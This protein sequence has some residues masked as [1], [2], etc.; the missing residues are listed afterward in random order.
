MKVHLPLNCMLSAWLSVMFLCLVPFVLRAEKPERSESL[1]GIPA[2]YTE[3]FDGVSAPNLPAGWTYYAQHAYGNPWVQTINRI[4]APSQPN[5][6]E[7]SSLFAADEAA[8]LLFISPELENI[9]QSAIRFYAGTGS[10]SAPPDLVV[11]TMS[12]PTDPST[13]VPIKTIS[14]LGYVSMKQYLV[15]MTQASPEARYIA[16]RHG[17]IKEGNF[18]SILL[19]NFQYESNSGCIEPSFLQAEGRSTTTAYLQWTENGTAEKWEVKYGPSGFNPDQSGNKINFTGNLLAFTLSFLEPSTLYDFYVR[20]MCSPTNPSAWAGPVSFRTLQETAKVPFTETFEGES[21]QQWSFEN[22]SFDN[23]WAIGS[24]TSYEGSKAAYISNNNG[25]SNQYTTTQT[26][27]N[28]VHFFRDIEFPEQYGLC[29]LKYWVKGIGASG[30]YLRVFLTDPDVIPDAGTSLPQYLYI[31]EGQVQNNAAWTLKTIALN[32]IEPGMKKRLVFSWTCDKSGGTQPPTAIDHVEITFDALGVISGTVKDLNDNLVYNAKISCGN[33]STTS[34]WQGKFTLERIPAG[35]QTLVCEGS[36]MATIFKE[37]DVSS[38]QMIEQNLQFEYEN[39]VIP[40]RFEAIGS[41]PGNEPYGQSAVDGR[42]LYVPRGSTLHI[43]DCENPSALNEIGTLN[44]PGLSGVYYHQHLY[45]ATSSDRLEVYD[46][47][48]AASPAKLSTYFIYGSAKAMCF[49]PGHLYVL[50]SQPGEQSILRVADRTNPQ[51]IIERDAVILSFSGWGKLQ[52]DSERNL[53]YVLGKTGS[54]TYLLTMFDC[55]DPADLKQ[56]Y[57]TTFTNQIT[58]MALQGNQLFLSYNLENQGYLAVYNTNNPSSPLLI[59]THT[60]MAGTTVDEMSQHQETFYL[61]VRKAGSNGLDLISII[62]DEAQNRCYQGIS[63]DVEQSWLNGTLSFLNTPIEQLKSITIPHGGQLQ[64]TYAITTGS[65]Y[66]SSSPPQKIYIIEKLPTESHVLDMMISPEAAQ[67]DGCTVSPTVGSH[68]YFWPTNVEVSASPADHWFFSHWE[69]A[70]AGNPSSVLVQGHKEVTGVFGP[71]LTVSGTKGKRNL[72][73]LE[74][75]NTITDAGSVTFFAG[76]DD[77]RVAAFTIDA[78]GNGN[79]LSDIDTVYIY[80]GGVIVAKYNAD[81]GSVKVQLQPPVVVP[82]NTSYVINL[83]YVF[84]FD[85]LSFASDTLQSFAWHIPGG[86]VAAE[87]LNYEPGLVEGQAKMQELTIAKVYNNEEEY[88]STIEQ[89]VDQTNNNGIIY[90]CP[91]EHQTNVVLDK[92]L[93]IRGDEGMKAQ[94]IVKPLDPVQ[95]VFL[96]SKN[97]KATK[98]ENLTIQK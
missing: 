66:T 62:Y 39:P 80:A 12:D 34:D 57:S 78:S 82:K 65:N 19:D 73:G 58:G 9:A 51:Q 93:T 63:T 68:S 43:F 17:G 25:T 86:S 81:N 75:L 50:A 53:L 24:A 64:G 6:I 33:E 67:L 26:E 18:K 42:Y 22:G 97:A 11:G 89:A 31:G 36:S 46:C 40:Y 27:A 55:A 74:V 94:T 49:G 47:N 13:F 92:N 96:L 29:T 54:N 41:V 60:F 20:A 52:L 98:F 91:A 69:G 8:E 85:P 72:C 4:W 44:L 1:Q 83:A 45:A 95:P 32:G 87:P 76:G 48:Q 35:K 56:V 15:G 59:L 3:N 77:W 84:N 23:A 71:I 79:D 10:S 30:D 5:L 37:I 2:P 14:D 38:G 21:A 7:M 61:F 16:F 90:L 88:F 70:G 28:R